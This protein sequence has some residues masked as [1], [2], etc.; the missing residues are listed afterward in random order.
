MQKLA[1]L[2]TVHQK[3]GHSANS[4][5]RQALNFIIKEYAIETILEEWSDTQST[6][7]SCHL[8]EEL[9]LRWLDIGTPNL[10]E[11]RTYD[12]TINA[13]GFNP[14]DMESLR[15]P[16]YGPLSIQCS[17]EEVMLKNIRSYLPASIN[18]GLVII[19]ANHLHSMMEKLSNHYTVEGFCWIPGL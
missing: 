15:V 9:D 2:G 18:S 19:G 5:F 10:P 1:V 3:L 16:R 8:A 13:L 14:F 4:Q 17:R 6:S 7:F 11:F 12:S